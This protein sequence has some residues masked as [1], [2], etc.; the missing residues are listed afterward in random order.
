[1]QKPQGNDEWLDPQRG[2]GWKHITVVRFGKI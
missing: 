1:M 2:E